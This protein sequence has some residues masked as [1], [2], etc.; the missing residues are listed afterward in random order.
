MESPSQKFPSHL[1]RTSLGVDWKSN[2]EVLFSRG[3]LQT[4]PPEVLRTSPQ[5][6][7]ATQMTHNGPSEQDTVPRVCERIPLPKRDQQG[8]FCVKVSLHRSAELPWTLP[9]R[10]ERPC[11]GVYRLSGPKSL[12][13]SQRE[14]FCAL[15]RSPRN[16]P[17]GQKIHQKPNFVYVLTSS[18]FFRGL[19]CRPPKGLCL[20]LFLRF[21][22]GGSGDSCKWSLRSQPLPVSGILW[23]L[24]RLS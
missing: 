2:L 20:R 3:N 7:P 4:S 21:G 19:F 5:E 23:S 14:S 11:T 6:S 18:G 12:K 13:R 24:R 9:L 22:P 16:Y 15:Q 8:N 17:R 10:A 1:L